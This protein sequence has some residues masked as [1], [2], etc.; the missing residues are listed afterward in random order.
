[1]NLHLACYFC[2]FSTILYSIHQE[3]GTL[4]TKRYPDPEMVSKLGGELKE[5]EEEENSQGGC[6]F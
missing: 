1:M 2:D 4:T 5:E 6:Q 3:S